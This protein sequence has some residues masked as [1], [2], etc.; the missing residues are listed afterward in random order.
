MPTKVWIVMGIEFL[1]FALLLF[2]SAGTLAWPAGWAFMILFFGGGVAITFVLAREDP[3][4]LEERM[5]SPIQRNQPLWDKIL[6]CIVIVLWLG[7]LVLMG[8]DA[9]RF[10]WSVM[11]YWLQLAGG[12]AVVV[13][14][15]ICYRTFRE[16]TFLAAVV[17]I[18][19]ER[20]HKVVSTGPYAVVRHPLYS[21]VLI[22]LPSTALML[23]SW[24][25]LAASS[26]INGAIIFRTVMEDRTLTRELEGYADYAAHVRYRL[27]PFIW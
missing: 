20:G 22:M 6:L 19:K 23:G 17:R 3:D 26:L 7:W 15:W 21:A 12:A 9:G 16:N 27:V 1:I 5:K 18:Q 10:R 24:Y 13:T 8:L 25:G 2:V 14:F 4:L 11:P